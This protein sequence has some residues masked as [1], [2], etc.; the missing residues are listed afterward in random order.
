VPDPMDRETFR[1][2]VLDW[3]QPDSTAGQ[4]RLKLVREL[5]TTRRRVI[6]PRLAGAAFREAHAADNGLLTAN[7]RMGDGAM[8]RL[9]ANLSASEIA[10]PPDQATGTPIWGASTGDVMPP[11]SVFWRLDPR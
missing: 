7:W 5:L 1:S 8:L 6:V 10:S 11:W 3:E 4:A 2:A 9:T